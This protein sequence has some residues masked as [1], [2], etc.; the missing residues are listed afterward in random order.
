MKKI[1]LLTFMSC[2]MALTIHAQNEDATMKQIK[3]L[4]QRISKELSGYKMD[5][6]A[7]PNDKITKKIEELRKYR[8]KLNI[9]EII[10]LKLKQDEKNKKLSQEEYADAYNFFTKGD[11]K[12]WLDNAVIWNYRNH[13][14][15]KELKV[16]VRFYKSS[17][18]KKWAAE[19]PVVVIQNVLAAEQIGV[20]YKKMNQKK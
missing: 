16:L 2:F 4:S 17:T 10:D 18:G 8:G 19:F 11:G 15:Y 5:T 14:T 6:V 3:N 7:V 13:F 12:K 20:I 9:N 1:L